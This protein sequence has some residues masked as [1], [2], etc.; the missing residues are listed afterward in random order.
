MSTYTITDLGHFAIGGINAGSII[1]MGTG[2]GSWRFILRDNVLQQL[3][4]LPDYSHALLTGINDLREAC[5]YSFYPRPTAC[6]WDQSGVAHALPSGDHRQT[7]AT[8]INNARTMVGHG[9][10]GTNPLKW[11]NGALSELSLPPNVYPYGWIPADINADGEIIGNFD[12]E[13]PDRPAA[14]WDPLGVPQ[15]VRAPSGYS[16]VRVAAINDASLIVG[17]VSTGEW[18]APYTPCLWRFLHPSPLPLPNNALS[19]FASD[20][21]DHGLVVG[22]VDFANGRRAHAWLGDTLLD[23]NAMIDPDWGWTLIHAEN[24][25]NLGHIVGYG[26]RAGFNGERAWL[27]RPDHSL[28]SD[29]D[30]LAEVLVASFGQRM[31][32]G[33]VI[34]GPQGPV[35]VPPWTPLLERVPIPYRKFF[36]AVLGPD[37]GRGGDDGDCGETKPRGG[38]S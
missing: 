8:A 19:G 22:R 36:S 13:W 28:V 21:N 34:V 2:S 26:V 37:V 31:Q 9:D 12:S 25:N 27:M 38:G 11:A 18:H 1:A 29:F 32:G 30:L 6:Y 20:I 7:V 5:G 3:H 16:G 14:Y 17:G 10:S 33:G 35:S 15:L 23:L 4:P 24:V